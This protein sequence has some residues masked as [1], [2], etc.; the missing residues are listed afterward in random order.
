MI[1]TLV[2]LAV[3]LGLALGVVLGRRAGDVRRGRPLS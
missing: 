2:V 3:A 1:L